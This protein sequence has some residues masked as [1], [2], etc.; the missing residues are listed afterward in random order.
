MDIKAAFCSYAYIDAALL[1]QRLAESGRVGKF[2][3]CS[4]SLCFDINLIQP[5]PQKVASCWS[6]CKLLVY[7]MRD[8]Q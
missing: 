2:I 1:V 8:A 5:G 7:M 3:S 6:D 4:V